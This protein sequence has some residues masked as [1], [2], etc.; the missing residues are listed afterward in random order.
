MLNRKKQFQMVIPVGK[1]IPAGFPNEKSKFQMV[2]H[3]IF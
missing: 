1:L 2:I 3:I